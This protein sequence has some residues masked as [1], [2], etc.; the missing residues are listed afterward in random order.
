MADAF[1]EQ[2]RGENELL[3]KNFPEAINAFTNMLM[4]SRKWG[5]S[6]SVTESFHSVGIAYWKSGKQKLA[7]QYLIKGRELAE[8][9]QSTYLQTVILRSPFNF[10]KTAGFT[11]TAVA[12]ADTLL[13]LND[14][15]STN[16]NNNRHIIVNALF[17]SE[18]SAKKI[19]TL[20][21]ENELSKLQIKQKNSINYIL[22][23]TAISILLISLLSYRNYRQKQILHQQRIHEL[24]NEKHLVATEAVLKGQEEER[25]RFAKDLH[26]GLGGMLSGIKYSFSNMKENLSM[27]PEN[28]QGFDR[29]LDMLDSSINELRRVAHSMMP[30]ALMKS[31]LNPAVNDF[32]TAI[33][34]SGVIKVLYQPYGI[35][36][37]KISQ[38]VSITIYRI[39]QEL[40]NNCIKHAAATQV[41]VQMIRE[42]SKLLLTVE[43]NGKGFDI[44]QLQQSK[45]IGWLNI[46]NRLD[47]L[48]GKVDIQSAPG[49]GTSVNIEINI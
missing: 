20:Q 42:D 46:H 35:D 44:A 34:S 19:S 13:L 15:L 18:Q 7:L 25:T 6:S 10:C 31:G 14:R 45:G 8:K 38:T 28:R 1:Y 22:A 30:D 3:K 5:D 9:S 2:A 11:V 32:C 29:G 36:D 47:Y 16:Q 39:V 12:T 24:E 43:D 33:N 17:G 48:K 26:D 41:V 37:L 21:Q 27:T 49:K 40:L 23:G 4:C